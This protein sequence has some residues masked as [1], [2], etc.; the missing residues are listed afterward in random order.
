METFNLE[1]RFE[2]RNSFLVAGLKERYHMPQLEGIP[3]QWQRFEANIGKV[4]GQIGSSAYG[5]CFNFD[6]AGSMDYMCGVEVAGE[7]ELPAAFSQLRIAAQRYAV[8]SHR[9]H[10][11]SIGNTWGA[12]LNQWLPASGHTAVIA[13]QF[14]AYGKDF[15]LHSGGGVVEIWIPIAPES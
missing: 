12:I 10:I 6:G 3:A 7:S 13:P 8:F 1:P 15:D 11:S 14:E 5:V 9:G 4:P 2:N